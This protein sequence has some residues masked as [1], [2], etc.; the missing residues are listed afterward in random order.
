MGMNKRNQLVAAGSKIKKT[1]QERKEI[2]ILKEV[3]V[4]LL[5][6]LYFEVGLACVKEADLP[7]CDVFCRCKKPAC[8]F[9]IQL[10]HL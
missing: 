3:S 6:T 4:S 9:C 2:N 7:F 8:D 5:F 1:D 10:H